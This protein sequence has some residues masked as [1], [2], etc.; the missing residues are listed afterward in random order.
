M[1]GVIEF[2]AGYG[3]NLQCVVVTG[4]QIDMDA[5]VVA[6]GHGINQG[7]VHALDL[8]RDAA[9]PSGVIRRAHFD[10]LQPAFRTVIEGQGLGLA[11]LD[12]NALG[13]R[14]KHIARSGLG[15]LGVDRRARRQT[16]Q[17]DAAVLVRGIDPIV[18]AEDRAGAVGNEERDPGDGLGGV[19]NK[20][21]DGQNLRGI[22][23]DV[24]CLG[25]RSTDL[26]RDRGI[27]KDIAVRSPELTDYDSRGLEPGDNDLAALVGDVPAVAGHCA[28]EIPDVLAVGIADLEL[29]AF[30]NGMIPGSR[31]RR[32]LPLR[33]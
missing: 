7:I 10:D 2:E 32:F 21:L 28:A 20:L 11:L 29:R 18:R 4:V 24:D 5:P 16:G 15:L 14:V 6:R 19:C 8:E 27:V 23:I 26:H 17:H 13:R 25:I 30:Q 9:E 1:R 33:A 22:I 3:L 31:L 12:Q